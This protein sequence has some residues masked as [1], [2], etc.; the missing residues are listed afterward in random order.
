M[1]SS[2]SSGGLGGGEPPL[3]GRDGDVG[4]DDSSDGC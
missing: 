2:S 1:T 4:G 3:R